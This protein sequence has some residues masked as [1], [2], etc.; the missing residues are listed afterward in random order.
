MSRLSCTSVELYLLEP[1]SGWARGLG[2]GYQPLG[3]KEQGA[4]WARWWQTLGYC[5]LNTGELLSVSFM[6]K[7]SEVI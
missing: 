5:I 6:K 1:A 2:C 7:H 4:T 3:H